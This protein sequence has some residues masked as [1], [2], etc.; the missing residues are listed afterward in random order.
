VSN[1]L[2]IEIGGSAPANV[3]LAEDRGHMM[4]EVRRLLEIEPDIDLDRFF[5]CELDGQPINKWR[6]NFTSMQDDIE[7]EEIFEE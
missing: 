3:F 2:L 6:Y 5:F 4:S 1:Y 7:L